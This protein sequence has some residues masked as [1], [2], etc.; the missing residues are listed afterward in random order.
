MYFRQGDL[1]TAINYDAKL[2][3]RRISW[4]PSSP[5]EELMLYVRLFFFNRLIMC[6]A[7]FHSLQ[8][9]GI[10]ESNPR[11]FRIR[12][13]S[14]IITSTPTSEIIARLKTRIARAL[15][16]PGSETS[17]SS[18]RG[19]LSDWINLNPEYNPIPFNVTHYGSLVP[20][21]WMFYW[22]DVNQGSEIP[23]SI[24]VTEVR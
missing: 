2:D 9:H 18:V 8:L 12:Q 22:F 3:V 1:P 23:I 6:S 14:H 11:S 24:K 16:L 5:S 15:I 10:L 13:I 20:R 17:V 19:S 7:L 4:D 21:G